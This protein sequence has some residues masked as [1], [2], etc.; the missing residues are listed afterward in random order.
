LK[1]PRQASGA[2]AFFAVLGLLA[3]AASHAAEGSEGVTAVSSRVAAGYV[4]AK[5]PDGLFRQEGYSFG[6]GGYYGGPFPDGTIDNLSFLDIAR[7]ISGPL[8]D[9][10]YLPSRD[11]K[12]TNLL[13][14]VYWGT[15]TVPPPLDEGPVETMDIRVRDRLDYENAML[16]GYDSEGLIGTEWGNMMELT[17]LR[18]HR[19]ELV[20]EI[21]FNRYF[22]VLMAYDFQMLWKQ[23]KHKLLWETRFSINQRSN[24][25]AKTLPVMAEYA[26]TYFG[27]D[28][29]GLM[30]HRMPE[31]RVEIHEPSL[32]EL[33]GAPA[34]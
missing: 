10:G 4:R 22:V 21:E 15:T 18:W 5:L 11:P 13:I 9:Q 34:K 2:I 14:M 20:S 32:I 24:D 27:Q 19:R 30:R 16:L 23:K 1:T 26:S 31:G 12:R 7:I 33:L 28:S 3:P 8:A 17:A 6:N 29:H 25:F